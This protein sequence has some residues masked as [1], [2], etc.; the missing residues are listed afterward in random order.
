MSRPKNNV[1]QL[2]IMKNL[3]AF[4]AERA[5]LRAEVERLEAEVKKLKEDE[6]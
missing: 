3:A 5:W 2:H 1:Q 6:K 4:L